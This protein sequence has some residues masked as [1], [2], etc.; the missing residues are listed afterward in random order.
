[1]KSV[2][3]P[4]RLRNDFTKNLFFHNW[5]LPIGYNFW[6][7]CKVQNVLLAVWSLELSETMQEIFPL[8]IQLVC[9]LLHFQILFGGE[10]RN[11]A[12]VV[13]LWF[14]LFNAMG[15]ESLY[16]HIWFSSA[17]VVI[18]LFCLCDLWLSFHFLSKTTGSQTF[19]GRG[20]ICAA[21]SELGLCLGWVWPILK[22]RPANTF[23]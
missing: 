11:L 1:M 4:P 15:S 3:P 10:G 17:I 16:N 18:S 19:A 7:V 5:R 13:S 8:E 14:S 12:N 20:W 23:C 21:S 9:V 22:P 6:N 2:R